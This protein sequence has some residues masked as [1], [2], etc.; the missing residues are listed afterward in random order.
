MSNAPYLAAAV[1]DVVLGVEVSPSRVR[2]A[3]RSRGLRLLT[4]TVRRS[5]RRGVVREFSSRSRRRLREVAHDLGELHKC[6]AML[7]LTLPGEWAT[8][9]P[10]GR[11]FKRHVRV[12]RKRLGR[13][14]EAHSVREWGA[15]WFLE[16]QERGAPHLHACFWGVEAVALEAM[17][18]WIAAAWADVVGHPDPVERAKHEAAGTKWERS[19]TGHFGYASKYASKMQQK[20]VPDGFRDVGR[21]WGIWRGVAPK[22]VVWTEDRSL[23]E[24]RVLLRQLVELLPEQGV[25]FGARLLGRFDRAAPHSDSFAATIYGRACVDFVLHGGSGTTTSGASPPQAR[26]AVPAGD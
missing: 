9:C 10:D 19:R 11:R 14:F 8:V 13:Y 4:D 1:G 17:R 20:R 21:F 25:R 26:G 16:F 15:L 3:V 2:F 5:S 18:V 22:P 7:T 23:G 6:E 24:V 12:L